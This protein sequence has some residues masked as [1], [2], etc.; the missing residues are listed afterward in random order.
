MDV[1]NSDRV[2]NLQARLTDRDRTL[3]AWLADHQ[4]LTT[5]Q[6]A[7]ALFSS[8]GFAQRRLL[9]LHHADILDRFRPLRAG[10]GSY[11]WHYVLG[12]LG[13]ELIAAARD[14]PPPRPSETAQRIRRIATSRTLDHR[15]GVNQFFTDLAGHARIHPDARLERWLSEARCAAPGAFGPGLVTP[16]RPDGHGIYT[17]GGRRVAFFLEHDTGTESH[18]VLLAKLTRYDAHVARG[19]LAWPVLFWLPNTARERHLHDQL[20]TLE[21]AVPIATA[22]HTADDT[23][24][25]PEGR[26]PADPVWLIH[27]ADH[28]RRLIDLAEASTGSTS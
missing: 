8:L 21:V 28:R 17:E 7:H 26:T 27:R 14:Q 4:V 9:A 24:A 5:P 19:G 25:C 20:T 12:H 13:A 3:L 22:T 1:G 15:L 2:L 10:G 16:I 23:G 18:A 11:P 6:I